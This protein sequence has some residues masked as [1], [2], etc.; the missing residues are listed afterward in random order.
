L[1]GGNVLFLFD[2]FALDNGRQ[3]MRASGAA[4]PAESEVSGFC[5]T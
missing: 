2:D 3:K 5:S 4:V 1:R